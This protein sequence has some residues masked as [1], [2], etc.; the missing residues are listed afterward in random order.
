M[1]I[2]NLNTFDLSL[3]LP[4]CIKLSLRGLSGPVFCNGLFR[5][6]CYLLLTEYHNKSLLEDCSILGGRLDL[7]EPLGQNKKPFA[8]PK[9][10]LGSP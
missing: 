2:T 7:L 4:T 1:N 6:Y 3:V 5:Y 8:N 9:Y 10:F